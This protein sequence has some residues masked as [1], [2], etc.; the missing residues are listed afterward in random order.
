[1][2]CKLCIRALL[3]VLVAACCSSTAFSA[4]K[5]PA[6]IG[7]N[8]V[9]QRDMPVPVWGW[10]DK[11]EEVTVTV[12]GQTLTTKAGDDGR[13]KVVLAKFSVGQPLE[14]TVKGSSGNVITIKNILVGEVWV[15]SGQ[16][17]M[18]M[19]IGACDKAQEEIA[20][21]NY[22]EIRLFKVVK[23]KAAQPA[24]DV[25]GS[26]KPCSPQTV[27]AD[28][29][30]GFSAAVITTLITLWLKRKTQFFATLL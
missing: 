22:P 10:A 9:F 28:G 26:W 23:A 7:D 21:A 5:M 19:G 20:A 2:R 25:Q 3:C 12:A 16:S 6:V 1:M 4:V 27:A 14:M 24:A 18:E 29:W 30:G 17:N 8:M 11:G 13:W 15:C